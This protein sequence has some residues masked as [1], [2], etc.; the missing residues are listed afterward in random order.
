MY[1]SSFADMVISVKETT[2][3]SVFHPDA[4]DLYN[5]CS[6]LKK[7]AWELWDPSHRLNDG[8]FPYLLDVVSKWLIYFV[9]RTKL[10][11]FSTPL[12]PCC[13][14]AQLRRLKNPSERWGMRNSS[15]KRNSMERECSYTRGE[16]SIS[17]A[18]GRIQF[19]NRNF[20][21]FTHPTQEREGLHLFVRETRRNGKPDAIY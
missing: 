19:R 17:I 9:R 16:T 1:L 18:P 13:A 4:Q 6:D 10:S 21:Q 7:V 8:V 15:L 14:S 3:F 20:K 12:P 11:N 5:T 2:V